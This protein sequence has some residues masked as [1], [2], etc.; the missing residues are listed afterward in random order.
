MRAKRLTIKE[1]KEIF[2]ALVQLED[3]A[4]LSRAASRE[5]VATRFHIDENQIS[6]IVDEGIEKDWLDEESSASSLSSGSVG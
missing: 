1:R 2:F 6:Q 4:I 3:E 5:Q